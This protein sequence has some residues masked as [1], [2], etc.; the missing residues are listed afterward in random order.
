MLAEGRVLEGPDQRPLDLLQAHQFAAL[1]LDVRRVVP[2]IREQE[3]SGRQIRDGHRQG[4]E[5]AVFIVG[6][7]LPVH[8]FH[9]VFG[10][11][12]L[13]QGP[14]QQGLGDGHEQRGWHSLA[15]DIAHAEID[16]FPVVQQGEIVKIAGHG[17]GRLQKG[18]QSEPFPG[19]GVRQHVHLHLAPDLQVPGELVVLLFNRV[20]GVFQ[21]IVD[22]G[23]L[24]AAP[25]GQQGQGQDQRHREGAPRQGL[26]GVGVVG[27]ESRFA[28]R[29]VDHAEPV[30]VVPFPSP[31]HFLA[32]VIFI[33]VQFPAGLA[34]YDAVHGGDEGGLLVPA[35]P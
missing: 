2:A 19:N 13:V 10:L 11:A 29:L 12:R 23:D 1:L 27:G 18:V 28:A 31:H 33:L 17:L 6:R 15:G 35:D 20:V 9:D 22:L 4:D 34:L 3:L 25:D 32:Q 8:L 30:G 16:F 14:A 7:E 24:G 26:S 5:H 21:L